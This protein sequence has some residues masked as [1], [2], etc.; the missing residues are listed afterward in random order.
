LSPGT[1]LIKSPYA[2]SNSSYSSISSTRSR[3]SPNPFT[4]SV[5][6]TSHIDKLFSDRVEIY[7]IVE[8]SIVGIMMGIIKILLKVNNF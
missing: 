7:G 1:A 4:S 3:T 8:M 2:H 5:Q 6:L